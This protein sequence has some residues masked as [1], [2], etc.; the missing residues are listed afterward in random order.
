MASPPLNS[1]TRLTLNRRIILA[2]ITCPEC[3]AQI[4]E[5]APQCPKCGNPD[6]KPY[7]ATPYGSTGPR[8]SQSW[9]LLVGCLTMPFAASLAFVIGLPLYNNFEQQQQK[10]QAFSEVVHLD[11]PEADVSGTTLQA[12]TTF[13]PPAPGKLVR[14]T[15]SLEDP[16]P[17]ERPWAILSCDLALIRISG[18]SESVIRRTTQ[19]VRRSGQHAN[20]RS[21]TRIEA[22]GEMTLEFTPNDTGTYRIEF[23]GP[24]KGF[25]KYT[26]AV[27]QQGL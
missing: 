26:L 25:K 7:Q 12:L 22:E 1:G 11:I 3:Q 19:V 4:S 2:L 16:Y 17:Y 5:H 9:K 15:V 13:Q 14:I 23:K 21:R 6:E 24:V 18:D 20:M 8:H 27:E 10:S